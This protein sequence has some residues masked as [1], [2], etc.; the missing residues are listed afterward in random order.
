MTDD[1]EPKQ[2]SQLLDEA[3]AA[4]DGDTV[5]LGALLD[6]LAERAFGMV[7]LVLALPCAIPFLYGVPQV[8]SLPMVFVAV[9]LASG[10]HTLW[11]PGALRNR[12]LKKDGLTDMMDKAR[13]WLRR[14]ERISN[15]RLGFLTKTPMEQVVGLLFVLFSLTIMIPL[16][17]TNTVPGI[18]IA[19]ASL[20]FIER[21][22]VLVVLGSLLGIAWTFFLVSIAGGAVALISDAVNAIGA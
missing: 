8:M 22:G 2:T 3:I 10:R 13:P 19:I 12:T 15:P 7:L 18:A 9:Q 6:V 20:G 1:A 17:A 14:F 16:P 11:L 5:P 21:D 4:F